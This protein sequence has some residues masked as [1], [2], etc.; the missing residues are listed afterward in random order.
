MLLRLTLGTSI[1][2][3]VGS[4][5]KLPALPQLA[6]AITAHI[7]DFQVPGNIARVVGGETIGTI[8]DNQD[9]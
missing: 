6:A 3:H 4:F 2:G 7:F 5:G 1:V 9:G 8:V